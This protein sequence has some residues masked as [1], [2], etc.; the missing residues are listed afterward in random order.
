VS[1][2]D[3]QQERPSDDWIAGF[4]DG[5]GCFHVAINRMSKMRVGWQVLPEFRVVQH[6]RDEEIL[7]AVKRV[8][9]CGH[10]MIN[11]ADRLELRVRGKKE[12]NS[13][14]EYFYEHPL[15]TSKRKNFE[16]FARVIDLMN[17][18][19]HLSE[20]GLRLIATLSSRMNRQISRSLESPETTC[21]TDFNG[22][23]I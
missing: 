20:E 5:E 8:F 11:H 4:V 23:K 15:H 7:H 16:I 12:L 2:A 1:G 9:G 18:N 17:R 21:R 3:N 14:V 22:Q 19:Y 10:V 6:R 13:I